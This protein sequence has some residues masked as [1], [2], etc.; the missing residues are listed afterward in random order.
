MNVITYIK[1]SEGMVSSSPPFEKGLELQ[2][3]KVWM[4]LEPNK[5]AGLV[6]YLLRG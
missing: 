3:C 6:R 5:G 1:L 2:D 4:Q